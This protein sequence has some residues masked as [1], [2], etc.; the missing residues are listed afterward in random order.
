MTESDQGPEI[1][2]LPVGLDAAGLRKESDSLGE[3]EVPA[4][5]YWGCRPSAAWS[6]STSAGTGC[7]ARCITPTGT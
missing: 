7:R 1:L 6:I 3:V 5:R 4:D 2:D